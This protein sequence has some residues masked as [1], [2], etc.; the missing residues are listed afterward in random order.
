M[1]RYIFIQD[2]V[3]NIYRSLPT[4]TF[5]ISINQV[6]SIIPNCR[7]MSYQ[8]FAQ[9][10]RCTVDDV[11]MLCES[12][13]GCT[14]YDVFQN[15]YLILYNNSTSN[16][17]NSGRQRWT[18]GHEIGHIACEHMA[19]SVYA[20]LAENSFV[21]ITDK[22]YEMEADYF[23][24]S[25]LAPFPLFKILSIKSALDIQNTF[26]LSAEASLYR[27]KQYLNWQTTKVKSAWEND[28]IKVYKQSNN[29]L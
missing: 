27:F 1:I 2:K 14:H 16:N 17:N 19:Y 10:N 5:P 24:A 15:R 25:L 26:G 3:L 8:K 13:S 28:M 4:I 12:T 11:I 7:I 22:Q 21:N 18:C 9:I 23:A 6:I 20:K 29:I